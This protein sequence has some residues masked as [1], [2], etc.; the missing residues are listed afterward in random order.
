MCSQAK[1]LVCPFERTSQDHHVVVTVRTAEEQKG[2]WGK[3]R[4]SN[5]LKITELEMGRG[6]TEIQIELP[7]HVLSLRG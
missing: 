5:L 7:V 4:L 1:I 2:N 6:K 3:E